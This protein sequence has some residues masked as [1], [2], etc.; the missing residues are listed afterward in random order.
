M[1]VRD[2]LLTNFTRHSASCFNYLVFCSKSLK[3]LPSLKSLSW[4][5]FTLN[6][7]YKSISKLSRQTVLFGVPLLTFRLFTRQQASRLF[8][9]GASIITA[10]RHYLLLQIP[11]VHTLIFRSFLHYP[12]TLRSVSDPRLFKYPK[13]ILGNIRVLSAG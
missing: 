10:T 8:S 3:E 6:W 2:W 4:A 7:S 5:T 9:T 1:L 12:K 13:I 11:S